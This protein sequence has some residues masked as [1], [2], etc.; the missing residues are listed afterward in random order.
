MVG[1]FHP[2]S[3][4]YNGSV[5]FSLHRQA[6]RKG[7]P[8]IMKSKWLKTRFLHGPLKDTLQ[9]ASV[10]WK[11]PAIRWCLV[12]KLQLREEILY[13]RVIGTRR[14][15][16]P[17]ARETVRIQVCRPTSVHVRRRSCLA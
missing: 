5:I 11:E 6:G 14:D 9:R 8:Q 15:S 3:V 7:M 13:R 12:L 16:P 1:D 17:F 4:I 2:P 10:K